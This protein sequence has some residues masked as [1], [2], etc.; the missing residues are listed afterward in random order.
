VKESAPTKKAASMP[1]SRARRRLSTRRVDAAKGSEAARRESTQLVRQLAV[2]ALAILLGLIGLAVHFLWIPAIVLMSVLFGLIASG[3]RGQ[4]GG[5]VI[6]EV[7]TSVM[8]EAM[9]VVEGISE[10]RARE[11]EPKGSS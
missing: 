5:G 9:S 7:A 10:H 6:S 4:R 1:A 3:L 2:L 8:D 11:P